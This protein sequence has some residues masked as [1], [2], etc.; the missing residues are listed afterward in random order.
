MRIINAKRQ[1]SKQILFGYEREIIDQIPLYRPVMVKGKIRTKQNPY[2]TDYLQARYKIY[3]DSLYRVGINHKDGSYTESTKIDVDSYDER[4]REWYRSHGYVD[5]L[6]RPYVW[7]AIHDFEDSSRNKDP[8]N[9][10]FNY[11]AEFKKKGKNHHPTTEAGRARE[12]E[13]RREYRRRKNL[14]K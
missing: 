2:L 1:Y 13:R 10:W 7:S 12:R 5:N 14:G 6:G 3:K 9:D 11:P 8:D 4:V